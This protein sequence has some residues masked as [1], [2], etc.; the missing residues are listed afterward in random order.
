M[1]CVYVCTL[2]SSFWR[3]LLLIAAMFAVCCVCGGVE[4]AVLID[5]SAGLLVLLLVLRWSC[6]GDSRK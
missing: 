4:V 1:G 6:V 3:R 5:K 2:T